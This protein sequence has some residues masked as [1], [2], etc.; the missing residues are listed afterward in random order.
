M[1][2]KITGELHLQ[3]VAKFRKN[4]LQNPTLRV[5]MNAVTRGNLQEIALN[6]EVL[7]CANFCFSNELE[8]KPSITDQKRSGTCWM[9]AEFNWIRNMT[10]KKFKIEDIEFSE[11]HLMFWDKVEKAN[12]FLEQMVKLRDRKLDD[13]EV[14]HLIKEPVPDGGEWH[15]FVNLIKKYGIM[16]K[17]AM[18]DT[19]N[20]E[21]SRF[22][23]EITCFKLREIAVKLRKMHESGKTEE[24]IR[25]KKEKLFQDIFRILTIFFGLPPETFDWGFRDKDKKYHQEIGITPKAFY[26]KYVGLNL[27]QVFTLASCPTSNTEFYKTY[28]NNYFQNMVGGIE[29]KWLNL[30]MWELKKIAVRMLKKSEAVLYGCDVVQDSHTKEGLM[31]HNLYDFDLIFQMPFELNKKNRLDYCQSFLTHSMVLTGVDLQNGKPRMWKVENSWGKDVGQK[32]FFAMSD[33]WFEEHTLD[34]IVPEKYMSKKL[35]DLFAQDPVVLP[36]WHCMV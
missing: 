24:Q 27:D 28:T 3:N 6:R 2:S 23:N 9:F 22:I 30:P 12:Y 13:R 18:P 11:N 17:S 32:G 7:N 10:M 29:W 15:M 20:R 34:L 25:R 35:L 14:H 26:E 31:Y 19:F 21:N 33:E 8:E 4:F 16:P 5:A 36:P 1:A